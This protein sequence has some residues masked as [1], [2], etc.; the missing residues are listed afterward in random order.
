MKTSDFDYEL[1][2]ELIAHYPTESRSSSRL[3]VGLSEIEH[4]TFKDITDYFEEGDLI[5][6][7]NTSVIQA[8]IFGKKDSCYVPTEEEL[9]KFIT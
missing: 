8:R 5:I 6:N 9:K 4:R 2:E 7:N 1:P 3:L